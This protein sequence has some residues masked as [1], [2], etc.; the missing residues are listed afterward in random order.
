MDQ[1]VVL[2]AGECGLRPIFFLMGVV[3]GLKATGEILSYEAPFGVGYGVAL[4]KV[5]NKAKGAE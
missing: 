4:I 2:D 5:D 3:G 1:N